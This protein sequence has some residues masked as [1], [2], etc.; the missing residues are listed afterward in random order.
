M[1]VDGQACTDDLG[2]A[3][4]APV[5]CGP[6]TCTAGKLCM[7]FTPG[8]VP[9]PDAGDGYSYSCVTFPPECAA[10]TAARCGASPSPSGCFSQLCQGEPSCKFED[11][12]LTCIGL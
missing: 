10:C 4:L 8:V 9:S 1:A 12:S 3:F 11:A 2:S 5:P 6:M 7:I